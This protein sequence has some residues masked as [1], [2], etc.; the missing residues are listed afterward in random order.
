M[1]SKND[2]FISKAVSDGVSSAGNLAGGLVDSAGQSVSGAGRGVGD[3]S[4]S[5]LEL[6]E[7]L[8][9]SVYEFGNASYHR[10]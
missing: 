6:L 7:I 3:R 1:S 2:N 4:V 5:P 8:R 9:Y 10:Q